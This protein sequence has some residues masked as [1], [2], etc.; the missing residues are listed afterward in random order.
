MFY[1]EASRPDLNEGVELWQNTP[2]A[3]LLDVRTRL[4][5]LSGHVPGS[6]S[7]PMEHL[8]QIQIDPSVPLFV[9]CRSGRR[10]EEAAQ[11]LNQHGYNAM[12]VGGIIEYD[13]PLE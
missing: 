1:F 11:W 9:Y 2:G 12:N 6:L 4:E 13:G 7:L 8:E 3:V 5:Y 10:S